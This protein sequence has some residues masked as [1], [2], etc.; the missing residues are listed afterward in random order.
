MRVPAVRSLL[1]TATL[2]A[3]LCASPTW[4]QES[5][6]ARDGATLVWYTHPADKWENALPLGNGRLGAM[7]FGRT[8]EEEIQLN[9]DTY[10]SGGPYS[11][12]VSGGF[13][14]LPEI[15]RLHLRRA[16]GAGPPPV[17]PAPDGLPRRAAEVPVARQPGPEARGQRR[18]ER[19]SPRAG[20][21]HRRGDDEL[22]ARRRPLPARGLRHPGGPG[23]RRAPLGRQSGGDLVRRAA[24]RR[25]QPGPLELRHR[26]LPDGRPRERRPGRAGQVGGLPRRR[27]EAPLRVAAPG[28][29]SRRRDASRR[30]PPRRPPRRR[31]DAAARGRDQLRQLQGR[32]RRSRRAGGRG[33]AGGRGQALRADPRGARPRAPAALPPRVREARSDAER[34]ASD[35]RAA[36]PVSTG[37]TTRTWPRWSSSSGAT[38]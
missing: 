6:A 13:A 26:L 24:S 30:R 37:R 2:A 35:G 38:C 31:G 18:G 21:G 4:G 28:V 5:A 33:D 36:R 7:V 16:A 23:P 8:D 12:T 27:R 11:T 3:V 15:R 22:R 14:A 32:E 25:A 10:W 20:P 1:A 34:V 19:L 17:R 29:S 9:D